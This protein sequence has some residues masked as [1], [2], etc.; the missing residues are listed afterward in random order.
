VSGAKLLRHVA[1]VSQ[2]MEKR[3]VSLR[4]EGMAGMENGLISRICLEGSIGEFL[5]DK[6]ESCS[7][8]TMFSAGS[9]FI[10]ILLNPAKS[11]NP[12]VTSDTRSGIK[13]E[14]RPGSF[15]SHD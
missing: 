14:N 15:K 2:K 9:P 13:D 12:C 1:P 11:A 5:M 3:L 8:G 4:G 6:V 7:T 10:Y